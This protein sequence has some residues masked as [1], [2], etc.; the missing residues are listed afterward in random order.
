[1]TNVKE[2]RIEVVLG[3]VR[4]EAVF[5]RAE[6]IRD[7]LADDGSLGEFLRAM[8]DIH[9]IAAADV[10]SMKDIAPGRRRPR[11]ES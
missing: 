7:L 2:I 5:L 9:P 11:G 8:I 3:D 6:K 10:E 1:M 4:R